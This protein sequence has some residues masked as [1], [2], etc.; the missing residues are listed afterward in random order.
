[1]VW[2]GMVKLYLMTLAPIA[3]FHGGGGGGG[4]VK[5]LTIYKKKNYIVNISG[6]TQLSFPLIIFL[7]W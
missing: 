7:N 3:D 2:Y 4:G 1:M 6:V 5:T